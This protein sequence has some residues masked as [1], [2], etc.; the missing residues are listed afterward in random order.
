MIDSVQQI[1]PVIGV[2]R[3][4]ETV[5]M[6][7]ATFYRHRDEGKDSSS[8]KTMESTSTPTRRPSPR[9]LGQDERQQVKDLL[10]SERFVD[11][12]PAEVVAT[13]LDEKVYL[14]SERTMYRIL[15]EAGES[16]ERRDQL[17]HPPYVKPELLAT[18]RG[19]YL[20][21]SHNSS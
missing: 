19:V 21:R 18:A 5:A 20:F 17:S 11:A 3:A 16:R 13:L 2:V 1:A 14:C 12:A 8:S 7:R 15:E 6:P 9:R 4:C 10:H